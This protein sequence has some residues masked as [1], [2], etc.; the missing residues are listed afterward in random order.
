MIVPF[1]AAAKRRYPALASCSMDKGFYTPANREALDELL[2]LNVM[3]KKGRHRKADRER[4]THPDFVAAR[5]QHPAVESAINNLHHRG[6]SLAC[7]F[8][9]G[10]EIFDFSG[11]GSLTGDCVAKIPTLSPSDSMSAEVGAVLVALRGAWR[12]ILPSVGA[13]RA[14]VS[15]RH[16]MAS[17]IQS[18]TAA[19]LASMQAWD[20]PRVREA[21]A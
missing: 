7:I 6:M 20:K 17:V 19:C 4:E 21:L 15:H 5:R 1:L 2:D 3:P 16:M 10:G 8:H 18:N 12:L 13:A 9:H 11:S 14:F